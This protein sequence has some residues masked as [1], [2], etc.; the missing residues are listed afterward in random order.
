[1]ELHLL[2]LAVS[3]SISSAVVIPPVL[4]PKFNSTAGKRAQNL[5][6]NIRLLAVL[7]LQ[8]NGWQLYNEHWYRLYEVDLMWVPAENFCRSM[9]GHLVSIKDEAENDFV[10][11]LRK[12]NNIWIGLNKIDDPYQVYKWSDGTD[13]DFLNWDSTQPNEP[14]VDCA[15]MAYHQEQRGTWFDYGCHEML[16]QYFVCKLPSP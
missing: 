15:Y 7:G 2:L 12:K 1:M 5:D 10:H 13:A 14:R 6:N 4:R 8:Q 16:P 11:A 9:G 3:I